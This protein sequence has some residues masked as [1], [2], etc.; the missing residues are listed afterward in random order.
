MPEHT[1]DGASWDPDF[2]IANAKSLQRVVT[3]LDPNGSTS[4]QSDPLLF[5]GVFI[6]S[7][8]LLSLAIEIAL[9]AGQGQE[10]KR[11]PDHTH[12]VLKLF[13][14]LKQETQETLEDRM[15]AVEPLRKLLSSHKDTFKEWRYLHEYA[16][17]VVQKASWTEHSR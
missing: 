5:S 14:S 7:P 1:H 8:V 10:Q 12:D 3:T 17:G 6:A 15:R 9:K 2:M 16:G 11:A 4:P 13:E